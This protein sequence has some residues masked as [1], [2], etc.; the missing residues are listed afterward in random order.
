MTFH[1]KLHRSPRGQAIDT[2]M[3][4]PAQKKSNEIKKQEKTKNKQG[5]VCLTETVSIG[6]FFVL[7]NSKTLKRKNHSGIDLWKGGPRFGFSKLSHFI[8]VPPASSVRLFSCFLIPRLFPHSTMGQNWKNC[9]IRLFHSIFELLPIPLCLPMYEVPHYTITDPRKDLLGQIWSS[10][11]YFMLIS[12]LTM[13]R[14]ECEYFAIFRQKW[15]NEVYLLSNYI[16]AY[17]SNHF[18]GKP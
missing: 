17:L 1:R 2:R 14:L 6:K 12:V 18:I 10:F 13:Q 11:A 15:R 9:I 5:E 8:T 3:T 16:I 4:I 7:L